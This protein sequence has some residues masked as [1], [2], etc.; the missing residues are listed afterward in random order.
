ME[1]VAEAMASWKTRV[2]DGDLHA[3]GDNI[4]PHVLLATVATRVNDAEVMPLLQGI[5]KASGRKGVPQGGVR[6]PLLSTRY[7]T[8][9][10]KMLARAKEVTR[11]G[12]ST[13][14]A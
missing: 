7:R 11:Q 1:R 2:I 13:S 10:D 3:Y 4:R 8:E 14:S 6:S 12:T 9:V 5:L